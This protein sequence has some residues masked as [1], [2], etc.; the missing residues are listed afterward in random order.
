MPKGTGQ[1]LA[2]QL[3]G[4]AFTVQAYI[5]FDPPTTA[6]PAWVEITEFVDQDQPLTISPGRSDGLSDANAATCSLTVDNTDGRFT[7]TNPSGAWVGQIR[8]GAWLRVDVLPLSGV[9]SR[10]F[11]GFITSLPTTIDGFSAQC[12][13]SASDVLVLLA[14]AP[15]YKSMIVEDFLNDPQGSPLIAGYWPLHE[16]AGAAYAS[17]VS[18]M[19]AAGSQSLTLRS[20]GVSSGS[21]LTWANTP[22]PGFDGES[23]VTFA[24]SG[25]PLPYTGGGNT[26]AL[27][28]GS[29]LHGTLP[30]TNVA[31]V[32]MWIKTTVALQP[33]WSWADTAHNYAMGMDLTPSGQIQVWQAAISPG[34][35]AAN[36]KSGALSRTPLN[37]GV[38]HQISLKIQQ[39]VNGFSF[40]ATIVDGDE[41]NFAFGPATPTTGICPSSAMSRFFLGAAEGWNEDTSGSGLAMFTGSISDFVVHLYQDSTLNPNWYSPYLAAANGHAPQSAGNRVARLAWLAG[42]PVPVAPFNGPGTTITMYAPTT[43]TSS[44]VNLAAT[45][46]QCGPQSIVGK[47]PIDMMRQA[48]HTENMPLFTDAYGR[49]TLQSSTLRENQTAAFTISAVDLDK[50]TNFP[51]DFQYTVNQVV[52]TP[53]GQGSLTVDTGGAASVAKYGTYSV[54]VDCASASAADAASLGAAIIGLQSDPPPRLAPLAVDAGT[55]ALQAGYGSAWYDAVLAATVSSLVGVTG[56]VEQSPYGTNGSS[57]HIVEGWTE[58]LTAGSHLFAWSTSPP[59]PPSFQLDSP[60]LGLLDN[61][62]VVLAY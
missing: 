27:P 4:L 30:I 62:A 16:P 59:H 12:V 40:T 43:G 11:T 54:S 26:G 44:A 24:P 36:A 32:T 29:F 7:A 46:H 13:I 2:Q 21:G 34:G 1:T 37:D 47:N 18:G 15:K 3:G 31:Q 17:D 6:N 55:L 35:T 25:T 38:W 49:I 57:S 23:T 45:A 9:V 52:V 22:A 50:S 28:N 48:A 61:P 51:D 8:K 20:F 41:V 10:R 42:L 39:P 19:A 58:T 14:N 33:I 53:S 56:W 5:S 60:T